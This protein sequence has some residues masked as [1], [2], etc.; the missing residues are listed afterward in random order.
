VLVGRMPEIARVFAYHGAEHKTVG[1]FEAGAELT[2]ETVETFPKE[3]PRCGTSF[4]VVIALL[5]VLLFAAVGPLPFG[6]RI[7][8]RVIGIPV[9]VAF[10]YEYLRFSARIRNP[11]LAKVLAA[12]GIWTQSLTTREPDRSMLEVAIA[13]FQTVRRADE[14]P[15]E[16][17]AEAAAAGE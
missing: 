11:V 4:L 7:V 9:L 5:S 17:P 15:Q 1:A 12:P 2:P 3:H 16:Q 8:S 6:W 13:A 10:G 14:P